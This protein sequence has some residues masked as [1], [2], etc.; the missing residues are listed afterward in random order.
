MTLFQHIY[1]LLKRLYGFNQETY[2]VTVGYALNLFTCSAS[3]DDFGENL[4]NL[5]RDNTGFAWSALY[6]C[7]VDAAHL[8]YF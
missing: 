4:L 7:V 8:L 1:P 6:G 3:Y 2:D 5:L